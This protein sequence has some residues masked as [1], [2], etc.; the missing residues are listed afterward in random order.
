MSTAPTKPPVKKDEPLL[1]SE[2]MARLDQLDVMSR[3]LLAGK[4]K[5]ERRSKRKGQSVEFADYRNYVA[6][7]DLRFLDWNLY[8][9]LDRLFLRLFMEEEDL[10]FYVLIDNSLSMDFGSPTKLHYAKQVAAALAF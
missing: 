4:M 1:T 8:A 5:G 7:D 3:K 2:F 6:G 10:H 9:R